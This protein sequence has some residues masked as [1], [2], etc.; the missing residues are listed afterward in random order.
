MSRTLRRALV[1][2][3]ASVVALATSAAG[4][5]D[6]PGLADQWGLRQIGAPSAWA[7]GA[8]VGA[9]VPIA[10][11]DTGIDRTHP[12]LRDRL[13]AA[14][15]C[16]NTSGDPA[17]CVVDGADIHG[18]GTHVAGIAAA[19]ANDQGVSGVAPAARILAIRVFTGNEDDGYSATSND[20]NAGIRWAL[21][22]AARPGVINLS[23]G[24]NFAVTSVFGTS[25]AD[26]INEAW[27]AGWVPVLASGNENVLG[28]G[29]SNYGSLPALVVGSTGRDDQLASYSSPTGNAQWGIVA[30]GGDASSNDPERSACQVQPGECI[31]STYPV[32]QYGYL[33]GTSMATPHVAG[34]AALLL[35][36]GLSN[37][38]AVPRL[39]ETANKGV[40][41]GSQCHGRLDA[42]KA[43]AGLAP[44]PAPGPGPAAA[45]TTAA[46]ATT[47][48]PSRSPGTTARP[49]VGGV[50]VT[51]A[52][53]DPGADGA[54]PP[55]T[56]APP[57]TV[58][59]I[60]EDEVAGV[61][62]ATEEELDEAPATGRNRGDSEDGDGDADGDAG[63]DLP[64]ALV[65]LAALA[66]AGVTGW[67]AWV[68]RR[69]PAA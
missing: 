35:G 37:R 44:A 29:S 55:A 19:T 65:V 62:L 36:A 47:T 14:V 32:N 63:D 68:W 50:A 26:G 64:P 20:I 24:G 56:G 66:A 10:V 39:L 18:H 12:D 61:A 43:T 25:F 23:L 21:R 69:R 7:G 16:V 9:G 4:V 46:P 52:P 59:S 31:L 27:T 28:L 5:G 48:P 45:P 33:Q 51:P 58:G 6:D 2:A 1:A 22:N 3:V 13:D 15:T 67:T 8:V 38:E 40:A 11:I 17:R 34:A 60:I 49:A 42:A 57:S 54:V 53:A 30:P 41:C